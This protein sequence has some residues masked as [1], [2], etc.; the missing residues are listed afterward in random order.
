M[1]VFATRL[2]ALLGITYPIIQGGLAHLAVPELAAAVSEAGALGQITASIWADPGGLRRAIRQV[3]ALTSRPFAVNFALGRWPWEGHLEAALEEGVPAITVTGGNP[4][5]VLRRTEGARTALGPVRRLVMVAGVRQARKAEALGADGVIAVGWEAGGHIGRDEVGTLVL[6]PRVAD[7]V[8][9]PVVAGGGIAD[10]RGFVAALALGADGVM[11]GT[12]F[13][14]TRE[15]PAH[16]AYKEALVAAAETDTVVIERSL[17]RPGRVLRNAAAE[18]ILEAEARGA[19]PEE[20]RPLIGGEANRRAALEGDLEGG[21]A[22]AGQSAG[23][24]ADV[25]AARALV[26]RMVAE[27]REVAARLARQAGISAAR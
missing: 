14:A 8:G 25:P 21:F 26:A 9:V 12:R 2:T 10:A 18:R 5:A 27:A 22:W 23:L 13:V 24:V 17:G 1:G 11:M 6:V 16:Q 15:C 3:R 20:L 19:G 7:A 4:E